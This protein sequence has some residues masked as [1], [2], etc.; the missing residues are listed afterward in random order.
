M[1]LPVVQSIRESRAVTL[2]GLKD[3]LQWKMQ[4][5]Q[6]RPTL[7]ALV[8]RNSDGAVAAASKAAFNPALTLDEA[9][10]EI[11]VLRGVGPAL[12][13]LILG[14]VRD[15]APFYSDEA[16]VKVLGL[17]SRKDLKYTLKEYKAVV[18]AIEKICQEAEEEISPRD[19]QW[20]IW[21]EVR[22]ES[23]AHTSPK[24]D[25]AKPKTTSKKRKAKVGESESG[26]SRPEPVAEPD[27]KRRS[28]RKPRSSK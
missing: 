26:D 20:K 21:R 4:H 10:K 8:A 28:T 12:G 2:D 17:K 1:D 19:M 3:L 23:E 11:T 13:S 25:A 7:P 9:L 14:I 22:G 16:A 18:T 5:G 24:E 27:A 6:R 15:D